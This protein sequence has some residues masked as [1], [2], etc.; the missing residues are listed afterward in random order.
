ML[1]KKKVILVG[2]VKAEFEAIVRLE[3]EKQVESVWSCNKTPILKEYTGIYTKLVVPENLD[4]EEFIKF[5][6]SNGIECGECVTHQKFDTRK[7]ECFLCYIGEHKNYNMKKFN[8]ITKIISDIIIYESENFFVKI[9]LGCLIPGMVMINPKKHYYSAA[10]IPAEEFDEYLE[11]MK[12]IEILLKATY[13]EKEPVIFFEHGSAPTGFSSHAKS[14]VHAHTHV[15]IGCSFKKEY[16]EA[17]KMRPVKDIREC[18]AKKYMS[19]QEGTD[20]QLLVADDPEV[21]VQ[22]QYP[23]QVIAEMAGIPNDLSNWRV[24]PFMKNIVKTYDDFCDTLQKK[25][26]LPCRLIERT[27]G[28]VKGYLARKS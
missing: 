11:V 20:G 14:I 24:E 16:L 7:E 21:Y 1:T 6:H 28:F 26:N 22:R 25:E 10:R 5:C 23:R 8:S 17:V 13:G 12:D 3:N 4:A 2:T 18:W 19:Y 9:E 15:A 27:D